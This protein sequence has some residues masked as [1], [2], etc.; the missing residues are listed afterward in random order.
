MNMAAEGVEHM[1]KRCQE[2]FDLIK[3]VFKID[4]LYDDQMRLI[5]A[6]CNGQN[7][8]FNAPTGYGKSIVFQS[9][10]WVYD[11]LQEQT[12]GISTLIVISPLKSLMEDQCN[13]MKEIGISSIALYSENSSN[14]TTA[15]DREY[16]NILKNVREGKYSLV[17]ASPEF[18]LGKKAW[19]N[20]LCS[21]VFQD[22]CIGVAYDEA[23]I[24][25]QW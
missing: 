9:L 2:A 10:P 24:I 14:A 12:I 5:K 16:E 19:R 6:F 23:H 7:I 4:E 13:H 17:F 21:E 1:N 3:Y 15:S 18:L 25:A 20:L 22:H 11:I 8:F